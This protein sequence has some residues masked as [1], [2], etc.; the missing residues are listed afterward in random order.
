VD[1]LP[2]AC[3]RAWLPD[4]FSG[5]ACYDGLTECVDGTCRGASCPR[6]CQPR[7]VSGEVCDTSEDCRQG[8]YCRITALSSGVGQCLPTG[9]ADQLCDVDAP[10]STGLL[11]VGGRCAAPVALGQPCLSALC[12]SSGYCTGGLDGGRCVERL[13]AGAGCTDDVQCA[14]GLLCDGSRCVPARLAVPGEAC[15]PRQ[16]CPAPST[17]VG[18]TNLKQGSC[19]APRTDGEPCALATGEC[20]RH[21]ACAPRDGGVDPRCGPRLLE[22]ERCALDGD[23][24]LFARCLVGTCRRIPSLGGSCAVT[25]ACLTG[26][27]LTTDAGALCVEPFGP[28]ASCQG[29]SDCASGRCVTGRCL[30]GCLP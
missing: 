10:C 5:Q 8:L 7:A 15:R 28:G 3:S 12:D 2:E 19:A 4:A 25:R 30:P 17:C 6:S 16:Q 27:C 29:N 11:C 26:S 22:G 9:G 23:C 21:L 1:S 24:Q 14:Q 13:D 20:E 18:A